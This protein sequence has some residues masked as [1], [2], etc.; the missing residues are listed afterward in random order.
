MK[1]QY[2]ITLILGVLLVLV[3]C[4]LTGTR[5][6]INIDLDDIGG[7][8]EAA[9]LESV[10]F[11]DH[12]SGWVVGNNGFIFH[13]NNGWVVGSNGIILYTSDGGQNWSQQP[14]DTNLWLLSVQF[15]DCDTGWAV[16]HSGLILHTSDG[17]QNWHQQSTD[18]TIWLRSVYFTDRFTGWTVGR[19][20]MVLHTYDGENWIW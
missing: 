7:L 14:T 12:N 11:A 13:T 15:T 5:T 18:T 8:D 4:E 10:F 20:G 17:G 9:T 19:N 6:E 2:I 3:S 16:G 1:T